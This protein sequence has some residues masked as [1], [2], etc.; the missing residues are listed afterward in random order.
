MIWM[1]TVWHSDCI[2]DRKVWKWPNLPKTAVTNVTS[3]KMDNFHWK[4]SLRCLL[5]IVTVSYISFYWISLFQLFQWKMSIFFHAH[6]VYYTCYSSFRQI[7]S[8]KI[9]LRCLLLVVSVPYISFLLNFIV[10]VEDN[11]F[12]P[13][14]FIRYTCYSSFRQIMSIK[15]SLR[16]LLL[17]VKV[18]FISF[19]LIFTVSVENCPI[20]SLHFCLALTTL[21]SSHLVILSLTSLYCYSVT[22]YALSETCSLSMHYL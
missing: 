15:K 21:Q 9:S 16:C 14:C 11:H 4:K 1:Q 10:S 17:I 8:I 3:E 20:F 5:L 18:L 22:K 7:V 2:L 12:F 19:L 6:F 13:A